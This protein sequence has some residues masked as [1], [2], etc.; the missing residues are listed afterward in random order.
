V[1]VEAAG[2]VATGLETGN[3]NVGEDI[4]DVVTDALVEGDGARL[5][6]DKGVGVGLGVGEGGRMFSQRCNGT[7]A[8]PI[9]LTSDS[10][11]I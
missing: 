2:V 3:A 8:P 11:R 5:G 1:G 7:L 4:P 9:S 10:Q 6:E